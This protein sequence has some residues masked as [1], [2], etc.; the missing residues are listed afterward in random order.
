[1]YDGLYLLACLLLPI[2]WGVIVNWIFKRWL[3]ASP[4]RNSASLNDYQI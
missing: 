4:S 1:M 3:N 2:A